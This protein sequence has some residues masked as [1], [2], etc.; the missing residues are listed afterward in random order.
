MPVASKEQFINAIAYLVRR[1][2]ENTGDKNFLR[3]APGM[4][5]QSP[6]WKK[7]E[8]IFL[9]STNRMESLSNQSKRSQSRLV[10][11]NDI[12]R[13]HYPTIFQNEPDTDMTQPDNRQ[14]AKQIKDK[15]MKKA[16]DKPIHVEVDLLKSM[17]SNKQTTLF[18]PNQ[19]ENNVVVAVSDMVNAD[20]ILQMIEHANEPKTTWK[21]SLFE[22]RLRSLKT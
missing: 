1:L 20:G 6:S 2:D 10:E 3:Y 4:D 14:W 18:D 11:Q 7:L 12:N 15:W 19:A 16:T 17:L 22:Y 21:T 9:T 8:A 13:L 5:V